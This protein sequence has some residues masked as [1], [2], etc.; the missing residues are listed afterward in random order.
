MVNQKHTKKDI[1]ELPMANIEKDRVLSERSYRDNNGTMVNHIANMG[2]LAAMV[3]VCAISDPN[4]LVEAVNG[5]PLT[6]YGTMIGGVG[7]LYS[8]KI[9]NAGVGLLKRFNV[10]K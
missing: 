3:G 6:V 2:T 1:G 4:E 5:D 9:Y 8:H 7:A 10:I